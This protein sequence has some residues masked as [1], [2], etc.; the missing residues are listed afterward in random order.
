MQ[1]GGKKMGFNPF[2][3]LE[4]FTSSDKIVELIDIDLLDDN[5]RNEYR[6]E[7]DEDIE[8]QNAELQ[9]SIEQDGIIQ[10]LSV[11]ALETGR[12]RIIAGHRRKLICRRLVESGKEEY[13]KIPCIREEIK[14]DDEEERKIISTNK[15]RNKNTYERTTEA[16]ILYENLKRE[17]DKG[18]L[19]SNN[20][21]ELV[22]KELGV[23]TST[24]DRLIKIDK[25]LEPELKEALK[26][27][28]IKQSPA[29]SLARMSAADQKAVYEQTG[30]KVTQADIDKYKK[31]TKPARKDTKQTTTSEKEE[32]N[33]NLA[34]INAAKHVMSLLEKAIQKSSSLRDIEEAEGN[35][36]KANQQIANI[37]YMGGIMKKVQADLFDKTGN[38]MFRE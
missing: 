22:A 19:K 8:K 23:S 5:P 36:E 38:N 30:G 20:L 6:T 27:G 11:R 35:K 25:G 2:E 15:Y 13:R 31:E 7:G 34:K 37:E 16:R 18:N 4:E 10:P 12:F 1:M 24:A 9:G 28:D 33:E 21:F 29:E 26:A 3:S 17:K 14:D 32:F